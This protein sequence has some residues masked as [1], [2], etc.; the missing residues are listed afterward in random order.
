V[1]LVKFRLSQYEHLIPVL[2][3]PPDFGD[4]DNLEGRGAL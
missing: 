4:D 1:S 3:V 2:K